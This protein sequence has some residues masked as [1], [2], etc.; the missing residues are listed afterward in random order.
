MLI[1]PVQKGK[2]KL[3]ISVIYFLVFQFIYS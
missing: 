2:T 1:G 3:F